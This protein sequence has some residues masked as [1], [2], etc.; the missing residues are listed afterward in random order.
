ME[1]NIY[2]KCIKYTSIAIFAYW[3][4]SAKTNAQQSY[5]KLDHQTS[6]Y[7]T[8]LIRSKVEFNNKSISALKAQQKTLS[9]FNSQESIARSRAQA[10]I[11]AKENENFRLNQKAFALKD[12]KKINDI[13]RFNSIRRQYPTYKIINYGNEARGG[14]ILSRTAEEFKNAPGE[15]VYS[16][17]LK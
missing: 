9:V 4:A 5:G 1:N 10:L 17:D 11:N 6:E 12:S 7:E 2:Y 13:E 8:Q 3:V 16:E 14:F 15:T